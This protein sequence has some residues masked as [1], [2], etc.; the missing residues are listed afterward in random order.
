MR[1]RCAW[2]SALAERCWTSRDNRPVT[3]PRKKL[4]DRLTSNVE[5]LVA[6][7]SSRTAERFR[8]EL[9]DPFRS[10]TNSGAA[11]PFVKTLFPEIKV[12]AT[13]ERALNTALGWGWDKVV[14]D[15][16]QATYGNGQFS[17]DVQGS[18]SAVSANAIEATVTAYRDRP[19]RV[20]DTAAELNAVL[21]SVHLAGPQDAVN[22]RSDAFY[23]DAAGV[24][25]YVEIKTPKPNYDQMKA[26]KRRILRICAVRHPVP[27]RA[28]VGMP[29][30]PN[31][32]FGTYG[33]P[34]TPIYL[35]PAHDLLVGE[36]FWNYVGDSP[37]TYDEMLDCFFEVGRTYKKDLVG[38]LGGD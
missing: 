37:D 24:E 32:R 2:Q 4:I 19:R 28:F 8:V 27:V 11:S 18:I 20:P 33:W 9:T 22:E 10:S 38:L 1:C 21:P 25:H 35:D 5:T 26:A 16:A 15:I 36:D 14:A 13:L 7:Y 12:A 6:G 17:Y 23:V 3:V 34:T 29:Y 30:N 31:G